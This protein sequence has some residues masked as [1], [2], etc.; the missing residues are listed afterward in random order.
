MKQKKKIWK[1]MLGKSLFSDGAGI[2]AGDG[3]A[4][5]GGVRHSVGI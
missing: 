5:F 4:S 2:D 3:F 1:G